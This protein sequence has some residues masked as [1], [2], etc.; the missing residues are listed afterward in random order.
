MELKTISEVSKIY[1][2]ST[3]TLRYYEEIGLI[4]STRKTGYA[5]RVYDN[6]AISR[7]Q[8]ILMFR[9]LNISLNDIQEILSSNKPD[10]FIVLLKKKLSEVER[11]MES[12]GV[13]KEVIELFIHYIVEYQSLEYN[14]QALDVFNDELIKEKLHSTSLNPKM[15]KE[16]KTIE[17]V[18]KRIDESKVTN[19]RI[20]HIPPMTV[21][22]SHS[23]PCKESERIAR[24][25]LDEFIKAKDLSNIKPD[26]RVFGFDNQ[27]ED[28]STSH[29][30]EFWV[31]IPDGMEG[32]G[33]LTKKTFAGGLYA[34][35]SIKMGDFHEWKFFIEWL[36]ANVEY[37]YD[38]REPLGMGGSLEEELN[39]YTNYTGNLKE[40]IQLD[41]LIPVKKRV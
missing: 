22:S 18:K 38:Q 20:V 9:K 37:D 31:S 30:Y 26:F 23:E 27:G 21:A 19:V 4:T 7:L 29:G 13:V 11:E 17:E 24:G 25:M 32:T 1:E 36:E 3:R 15:L 33:P 14:I 28:E 12:L 41:L 10:Q 16:K 8:I 40:C 35:H 6:E 39:A 2:V 5:Y 34:A